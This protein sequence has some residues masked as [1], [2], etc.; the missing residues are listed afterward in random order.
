MC[1]KVQ[2]VNRM[3]LNTKTW[4]KNYNPSQTYKE[5]NIIYNSYNINSRYFYFI[6]FSQQQQIALKREA[7]LNTL[8]MSSAPRN[9]F[10]SHCNDSFIIFKSS[11]HSIFDKGILFD[12]TV[13]IV[14]ILFLLN[15][16]V[17]SSHLDYA[18]TFS[19]LFGLSF[20]P[21]FTYQFS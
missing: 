19:S 20:T 3:Q 16:Y 8:Q 15:N 1:S 18:T 14:T 10:Y 12:V 9:P 13:T 6:P 7:I 4:H 21:S 11:G 5:A 2:V 17:I